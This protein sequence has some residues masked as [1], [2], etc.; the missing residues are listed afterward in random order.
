MKLF[1]CGTCDKI[2]EEKYVNNH[3]ASKITWLDATEHEDRIKEIDQLQND[4]E[5]KDEEES[6]KAKEH[7][8]MIDELKN[9]LR[10]L[11][12]Q[13]L[14][15]E[16]LRLSEEIEELKKQLKDLPDEEKQER[17]SKL[18]HIGL[19]SS[20][21]TNTR[22]HVLTLDQSY[23]DSKSGDKLLILMGSSDSDTVSDTS[24]DEL[25]KSLGSVD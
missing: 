2:L 18:E 10:K 20:L 25:L 19:D 12:S 15:E 1:Q 23:R 22:Y 7:N 24:G 11:S 3:P 14:D 16:I 4:K 13:E 17:D 8:K 21:I 5:K 9:A 6:R